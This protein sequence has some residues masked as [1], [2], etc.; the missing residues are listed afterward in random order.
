MCAMIRQNYMA[1]LDKMEQPEIFTCTMFVNFCSFCGNL[2]I[3][4][5]LLVVQ[6]DRLPALHGIFDC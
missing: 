6:P 1:L 5:D 3:L 4:Y 2:Y